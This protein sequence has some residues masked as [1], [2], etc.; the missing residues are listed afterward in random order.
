M[1]IIT[2]IEDES[3]FKPLFKNLDTWAS[4]QTFLKALFGLKNLMKKSDLKLYRECTKRK[5]IPKGGFKEAY[6]IVGRRGGKSFISA[7]IAVYMA[8]FGGLEKHLSKGEAGWVFCI[9]TDKRQAKIVLDFVAAFLELFPDEVEDLLTWEVRLKNRINIAV[10]PANFR[11]GRGYTTICIIADEIA[12]MRD[13]NSA[14][15]FSEIINSLEPGL[16]D[17]GMLIGISSVYS[18]FGYLFD[19]HEEFFGKEDDI[20]IWKADTLTM[21][22]T[23][24]QKKIDRMM[25]RDK[26]VALAEYYSIWR[27]DLENFL[28]EPLIAAAMKDGLEHTLPFAGTTYVAFTDSSSGRQDSFTLGLAH[29]EDG[30]IIVDKVLEQK[31]PFNPEETIK[32]FSG[33]LKQ[34]GCWRVFGDKYAS[35]FVS[36]LFRKNSVVYEESKL[37]KSEIYLNAQP[38]FTM[39]KIRLPKD[40]KLKTQLLLLERKPRSGGID[41]ID[42]PAKCH[43]DKANSAL[44]AAVH[45]QQNYGRSVEELLEGRKPVFLSR[46]RTRKKESAQAKLER[47][48]MKD[49]IDQVRREEQEEKRIKASKLAK[50]R[51]R[52]DA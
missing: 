23:F 1:N 33:V 21:N 40:D 37:T 22:P 52:V 38:L 48:V 41:L 7:L 5:T 25:K 8:L 13:E 30:L 34:Y 4:W 26:S 46:N 49:V 14:N 9:A 47:E 50:L 3:L 32:N 16:L 29:Q 15:P 36:N 24:S 2:A 31:P 11:A 35:G 51:S 18:R 10:K 27:E 6:A 45:L 19:M 17:E 44:G 42:H 43:D 39:N 20:L 12:F 28:S